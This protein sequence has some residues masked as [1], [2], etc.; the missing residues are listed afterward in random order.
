MSLDQAPFYCRLCLFRRFKRE[1]L[2]KHVSS[3]RRHQLVLQEKNIPDSP[4]FLVSNPTPYS[5]TDRDVAILSA[6][7]SQR[8]WISISKK[9]DILSQAMQSALPDLSPIS[10]FPLSPFL[11]TMSPSQPTRPTPL[12]TELPT[13][14][15][16]QQPI[17][18]INLSDCV[19][20]LQQLMNVLG[21]STNPTL[22]PNQATLTNPP[23]PNVQSSPAI[24]QE[25]LNQEDPLNSLPTIDECRALAPEATSDTSSSSSSSSSLSSASSTSSA[26]RHKELMSVL[27]QINTN[28]QNLHSEIHKQYQFNYNFARSMTDLTDILRHQHQ[29]TQSAADRHPPTSLRVESAHNNHQHHPDHSTSQ[30]STIRHHH[31]DRSPLRSRN[32]E[33]RHEKE[34]HRERRFVHHRMY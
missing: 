13:Q 28:L 11:Q 19:G 23:P 9:Q 25:S 29:S 16:Q 32:N 15:R 21:T 24:Q 30:T 33:A 7:D 26:E 4:D 20:P 3:F 34:N 27:S 1:E 10:N 2:D 18:Y 6:E 12:Q 14:L 31:R 22:A 8:H 17:T 5:I